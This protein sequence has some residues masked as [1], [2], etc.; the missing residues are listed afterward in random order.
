M[1]PRFVDGIVRRY[2]AWCKTESKP[3]AVR[4]NGKAINAEEFTTELEI[5]E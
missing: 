5:R 1:E 3:C 4:R 2:M